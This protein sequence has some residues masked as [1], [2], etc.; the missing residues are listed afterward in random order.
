MSAYSRLHYRFGP[1]FVANSNT[2]RSAHIGSERA[3]FVVDF[4]DR[5]DLHPTKLREGDLLRDSTLVI[6][7]TQE[8]DPRTGAPT[9]LLQRINTIRYNLPPQAPLLHDEMRATLPLA[10]GDLFMEVVCR[11]MMEQRPAQIA[12]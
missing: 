6:S 2:T 10:N 11:H 5:D 8:T 12:Q 7:L 3:V 9:V 1:H 4:V